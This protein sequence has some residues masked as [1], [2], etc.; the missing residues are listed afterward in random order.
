MTNNVAVSNNSSAK[1]KNEYVVFA[2]LKL[3]E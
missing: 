2:A 3:I 1:N